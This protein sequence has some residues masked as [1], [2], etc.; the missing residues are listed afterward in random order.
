MKQSMT[1]REK[2]LITL[3]ITIIF[4]ALF[5]TYLILPGIDKYKSAQ[6][7]LTDASARLEQL[8]KAEET[9]NSSEEEL[10]QIKDDLQ[11][12]RKQLPVSPE[13]AEL[14]YYL[15]QA[16]EKSGVSL[17]KYEFNESEAD[18]EKEPENGLV[19]VG[20]KIG[21]LGTY[22]QVNNFVNQTEDLTRITHNRV[23]TINEIKEKA[24]LEC[25]IEFTSYV[26]A[27][28]AMNFEHTGDIPNAAAGKPSPFKF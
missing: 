1:G 26:A 7:R 14:L 12:Y 3:A 2:N 23:I 20:G 5:I 25:T 8:Q 10:D 4:C 21:V 27:Y 18:A 6:S 22:I 11:E 9:M 13:S 19:L 16:A 15:N 17:T 28:G 24:A